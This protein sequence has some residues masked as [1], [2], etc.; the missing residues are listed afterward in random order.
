MRLEMTKNGILG[1]IGC[2]IL[3]DEIVYAVKADR[4]LSEVYVVEDENSRNLVRKLKERVPGVRTT[5]I[6]LE[7]MSSLEPSGFGIAVL[8]K[9]MAL[10]EDPKQLRVEVEKAIEAFAPNC[11]SVLLFYGLC[12]NAFKDMPSLFAERPLTILTD[13]QGN[14]VDDCIATVLGGTDG[15]YKLLKRYPGVF[16]LTP[17][18]AENWREL[19]EK[20]EI[21]R[22][23]EKGDLSM[24]KWMFDA[25]GYK[26]A[27]KIQTGHADDE[28]FEHQVQDF[29][30][31]FNFEKVELEKEWITMEAV[32]HAYGNAK[33]R[34]D[35]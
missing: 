2:P 5:L 24:L 30:H 22:G 1:I 6:G 32:D 20:M 9:P 25:A 4:E 16:Y 26:R 28:A 13:L 8:M 19:I 18:W 35:R 14:P 15:Y 31:V 29:I 27:L 17:A 12:G 3:E 23:I 33:G 10:H 7:D 21:T 34:M 11:S